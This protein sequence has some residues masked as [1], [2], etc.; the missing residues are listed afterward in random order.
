LGIDANSDDNDENTLAVGQ[1]NEAI[2]DGCRLMLIIDRRSP[3]PDDAEPDSQYAFILGVAKQLITIT[4]VDGVYSVCE[5]F[6]ALPSAS[7]QEDC[8]CPP[9]EVVGQPRLSL[10]SMPVLHFSSLVVLLLL[11]TPQLVV[12]LHLVVASYQSK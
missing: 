5:L 10:P 3:L 8:R 2:A 1:F 11:Q 6:N 9:L 7:G 4:S 12:R